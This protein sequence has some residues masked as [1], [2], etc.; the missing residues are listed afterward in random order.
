MEHFIDADE[1]YFVWLA[2]YPEGF[3]VNCYRNPTASYLILHR[4]SCRHIQQREGRRS[5]KDYGKVCVTQEQI[6]IDWAARIGGALTEC[7][8]CKP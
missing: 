3:V 7:G 1:R 6:L 4:A 5:T 8:F 2:T